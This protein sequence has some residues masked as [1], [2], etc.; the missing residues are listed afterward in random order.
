M[1]AKQSAE[2]A[3]AEA[4][5]F[6]A[7]HA[8]G[9]LR[10]YDGTRP[11]SVAA[12]LSGN[13]ELG[14]LTFGASPWTA[15]VVDGAVT[16]TTVPATVTPVANG[17]AAFARSFKSDGTTAIADMDVDVIGQPAEVQVATKT[18]AIGTPLVVSSVTITFPLS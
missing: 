8:S 2:A 18:F 10:F 11:A 5:A 16:L 9:S 12:A 6:A 3:E 13:T 14:R 15:G 4:A 1:T 7:L 17:V